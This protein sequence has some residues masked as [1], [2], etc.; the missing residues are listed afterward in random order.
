MDKEKKQYDHAFELK[1][2]GKT[3]EAIALFKNIIKE[4][5]ESAVANGMIANLY[6]IKLHD[7]VSALPYAKR[8]V[9]LSPKSELASMALVL[10]LFEHNYKDEINNEIRRYLRVG[11]KIDLYKTLLRE[12]GLNIEDFT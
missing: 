11:K 7:H 6:Y 4:Y 10:C 12:N 3:E 1:N 9:E 2:A 5:G 8:A